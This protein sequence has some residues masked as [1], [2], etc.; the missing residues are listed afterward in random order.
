MTLKRLGLLMGVIAALM[1]AASHAGAAQ[2]TQ[3]D[4]PACKY[5]LKG[6]IAKGDL[7]ELQATEIKYGDSLCL[8]SDGGSYQAG[9]NIA[10][11]LVGRGIYTVIDRKSHCFS[12]CAIIFMA[13]SESEEGIQLS[14]RRMHITAQLGFHAPYVLPPVTSY[15]SEHIK[16]AYAVGL[17]AVARMMTLGQN[18]YG[19]GEGHIPNRVI[20]ELLKKGPD[21]VYL[22]DTVLKSAELDI[23][24]FGV[25]KARWAPPEACNACI[26]RNGGFSTTDACDRARTAPS[27]RVDKKTVEYTFNGFGA[28]GAS[29]CVVRVRSEGDKPMRASI[30]TNTDPEEGPPSGAH[31][32]QLT[33][34]DALS[35]AKTFE[36]LTADFKD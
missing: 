34:Q 18:A 30:V 25:P 36:E 15:T 12:S 3:V 31:F 16:A 29:S 8:E 27:R 10:E 1:S 7:E 19:L 9:L 28:E 26:V 4:R 5:L 21:E 11:Y 35:T 22:V 24:L 32:S 2:V 14:L 17:D 33:D 6:E 20:L 23:Q 13:G